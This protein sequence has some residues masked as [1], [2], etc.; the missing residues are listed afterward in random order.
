MRKK[1]EGRHIKI[2]KGNAYE[3]S[4]KTAFDYRGKATV[5]GGAGITGRH[6]KTMTMNG[7]YAMSAITSLTAQKHNGCEKQIQDASPDF[8]RQQIDAVFED[9]YPDAVKIGMVSSSELI[10]VIGRQADILQGKKTLF[11]IPSWSRPPAR[12]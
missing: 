9:I 8:L 2:W 11:S 3:Q 6:K 7:V 10:H 12:H 4:K 5:S 1:L